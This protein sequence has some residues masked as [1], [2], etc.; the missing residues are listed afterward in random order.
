[1]MMSWSNPSGEYSL[2]KLVNRRNGFESP[3]RGLTSYLQAEMDGGRLA[4]SDVQVLG[5]AFI[6]G[7]RDYC[8]TELFT[9]DDLQRPTIQAFV[10]GLVDLLFRPPV[11]PAT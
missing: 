1:M 9:R 6:G 2:E 8:M 3:L 7:L 5:R 11:L 10:E 4:H